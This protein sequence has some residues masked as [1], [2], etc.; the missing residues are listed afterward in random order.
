L[1]LQVDSCLSR[2]E[3]L[4]STFSKPQQQLMLAKQASFIGVKTIQT[5]RVD[6]RCEPVF[7][8]YVIL[9][10]KNLAAKRSALIRRLKERG[11][12]TTFGTYHLPLTA[13]YRARYGFQRGDFPVTND[14]SERALTMP[15]YEGLS[16]HDQEKVVQQ[17]RE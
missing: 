15:L 3:C 16:E 11:V 1:E 5:P 9:L 4:C 12:E 2:E 13:F 7:Q 17:L 10:P 14:V 8:S 6:A